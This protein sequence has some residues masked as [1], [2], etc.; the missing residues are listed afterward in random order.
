[1]KI[2]EWSLMTLWVSD[3]ETNNQMKYAHDFVPKYKDFLQNHL[4]I[5]TGLSTS[6]IFIVKVTF[7]VLM[8]N[9]CIKNSWLIIINNADV[10]QFHWQKNWTSFIGVDYNFSLSF[11]L[12]LIK[13]VWICG[14]R[15]NSIPFIDKIILS[16]QLPNSTY[17]GK[18]MYALLNSRHTLM[19]TSPSGMYVVVT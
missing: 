17:Y 4:H 8:S 7:L 14:P 11:F 13:L 18:Y 6:I 5:C 2:W 10:Y 15:I 16:S 1:M 3:N 19:T 12:L 9:P